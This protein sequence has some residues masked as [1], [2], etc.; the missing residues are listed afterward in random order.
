[1]KTQDL[2]PW[3]GFKTVPVKKLRGS[4]GFDLIGTGSCDVLSSK[5]TR[6]KLTL[7]DKHRIVKEAQPT[8]TLAPIL[9]NGDLVAIKIDW[10]TMR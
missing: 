3:E 7:D 2:A 9:E 5:M 4:S 6:V 10:L 8:M 1:M